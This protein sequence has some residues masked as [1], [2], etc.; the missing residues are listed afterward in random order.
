MDISL[1]R[2]VDYLNEKLHEEVVRE[3]DQKFPKNSYVKSLWILHTYEK[4]GG[5]VK[6]SGK[7]KN[8]SN[9]KVQNTLKKE[10]QNKVRRK[11]GKTSKAEVY[12]IDL[13]ASEN[14]EYN[15]LYN[16]ILQTDLQEKDKQELIKLHNEIYEE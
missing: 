11:E 7:D 1:A 13:F 3:A 8:P 6:Y 15:D 5:K 9:K 14:S 16:E 4:K 12:E 10:H 2:K